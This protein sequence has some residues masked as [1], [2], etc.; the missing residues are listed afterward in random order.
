MKMNIAI[1]GPAGSGKSTV[2][3]RLAAQMGYIY[4]DTG[5][6]YRAMALYC[7]RAGIAASDEAAVCAACP[8]MDV[9]IG[10]RDGAQIV[11]LN[12]EDVSGLIRTEE[13]SRAT[14]VIS[15]YGPVR[16]HLLKLQRNLAAEHDVIM[17]GRDIGTAV[18]PDAPCK[19]FLT[20]SVGTRAMRRYLEQK[21]KGLDVTLEEIEA[22][23]RIRD[24]RDAG[25]EIAPLKKAEDAVLVDTSDL[26]V[27]EVVSRIRRIA[28][29]KG[30]V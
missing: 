3:R 9:S 27:D 5:A 24:E 21:E 22:D 15:V 7:L 20:A 18:L 30:S 6:M 16:A 1:D 19:I 12:G 29:E 4:V 14:S 28:Q 13:V 2:A 17:D 25:R 11:Y 23:I 10:H 26:T 8:D